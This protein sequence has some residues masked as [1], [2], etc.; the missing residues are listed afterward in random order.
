MA[1]PKRFLLCALVL[2]CILL[3]SCASER[4]LEQSGPTPHWVTG[5]PGEGAD[6]LLFAGQAVGQNVL[7]ERSMR[8]RAME[9]ARSQIA[10]LLE[11]KVAAQTKEEIHREGDAALGREVSEAEYTR[12]VR[13][14]VEQNIRGVSQ[15]GKYWEKWLI[16]PGLF[17]RS[18]TRYKYYVLA[19][20]PRV[21][22]E[23]NLQQFTRLVAEPA[24]ARE[25]IRLGRPVAAARLLE[26]LLDDYPGAPVPVR[27]ALADAY[28]HAGMIDSAETVLESALDLTEDDAELARIRERIIRVQGLFPDLSGK[29]AYVLLESG[30]DS[31]VSLDAARP[32]IEEACVRGHLDVAGV[33]AGASGDTERN[34]VARAG[35]SGADWLIAV[36]MRRMQARNRIEPYGVEAYE[37]QVECSVRVLST[38]NADLLTSRSITQRGLGRDRSSAE[39]SAYRDA[40]LNALRRSFMSLASLEGNQ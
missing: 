31:E 27:L 5:P 18:F 3:T 35:K 32:W 21:E 9:D 29:S 2:P 10:G 26:A 20:Y 33:E 6:A 13:T 14:S 22:Y 36:Q 38:A 1:K 25:L 24:Q 17:R 4:L 11:T 40:V 34:V 8:D 19:A 39:R 7:D 12:L 37:V 30:G 23:R 15:E 16:A 28:E